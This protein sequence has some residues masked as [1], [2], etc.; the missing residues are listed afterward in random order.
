MGKALRIKQKANGPWAWFITASSSMA[1]IN[2]RIKFHYKLDI[3]QISPLNCFIQFFCSLKRV[4]HLNKLTSVSGARGSSL[5]SSVFADRRI[6]RNRDMR[7]SSSDRRPSKYRVAM[8]LLCRDGW[9]VE[10][11]GG[12]SMCNEEEITLIIMMVK[13]MVWKVQ[14]RALVWVSHNM[15]PW[16]GY[17]CVWDTPLCLFGYI[18]RSFSNEVFKQLIHINHINMYVHMYALALSEQ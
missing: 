12:R 18:E 11:G 9:E 1:Q 14:A 3:D 16:G 7:W 6:W 15:S 10:G 4:R 8:H 5:Y 2:Y 13:V 17:F